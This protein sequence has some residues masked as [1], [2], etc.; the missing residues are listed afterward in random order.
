[1]TEKASFDLSNQ[2]LIKDPKAECRV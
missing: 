2:S 1:L